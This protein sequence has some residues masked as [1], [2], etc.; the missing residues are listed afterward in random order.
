VGHSKYSMVATIRERQHEIALHV[1][2]HK[3]YNLGQRIFNP[4]TNGFNG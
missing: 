3:F 4:T 1:N 2:L